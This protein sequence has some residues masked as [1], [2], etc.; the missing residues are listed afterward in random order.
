MSEKI[1]KEYIYSFVIKKK[2]ILDSV[3]VAII[4]YNK[5][6]KI[7][8]WEQGYDAQI[9]R[10]TKIDPLADSYT[11]WS[12]YCFAFDD[13]V[14]WN[15]PLGAEPDP[16]SIS[17]VQ[18]LIDYINQYTNKRDKKLEKLKSSELIV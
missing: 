9:G 8:V 3:L 13:P 5:E 10:F 14:F 11:D 12:P 17:T 6:G 16:S 2:N 1:K 18:D 4:H 7:I 15:D